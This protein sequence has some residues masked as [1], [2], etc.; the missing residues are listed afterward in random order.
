MTQD[1]YNCYLKRNNEIYQDHKHNMSTINIAQKYGISRE[2][3]REILA[4]RKRYE[5]LRTENKEI[6]ALY[7]TVY[8]ICPI[9][10]ATRLYHALRR[11]KINTLRELKDYKASELK[12]I[13][14][15]GDRYI[16]ILVNARLLAEEDT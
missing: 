10:A 12:R 2:R 16:T 15:I 11:G 14:G 4:E 8:K 5:T 6:Y 13:R 3:V 7:E 1:E 9:D